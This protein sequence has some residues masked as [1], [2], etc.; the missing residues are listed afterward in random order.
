MII[1]A[2]AI[3]ARAAVTPVYYLIE[4][5]GDDAAPAP[6]AILAGSLE[7]CEQAL[8]VSSA[9]RAHC[10]SVPGFR[11]LLASAD[12]AFASLRQ[13]ADTA[14]QPVSDLQDSAIN[15][16]QDAATAVVQD[17]AV[18]AVQDAIGGDDDSPLE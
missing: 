17:A 16:V 3:M 11:H 9:P 1:F 6:V 8:A 7:R 18:D 14:L 13:A 10:E 2:A 5:S 12:S 15:A 4:D